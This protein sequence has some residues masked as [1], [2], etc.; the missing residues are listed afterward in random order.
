VEI[1]GNTLD[2]LVGRS[3]TAETPERIEERAE[4][5]QKLCAFLRLPFGH[6][7]SILQ[8]PLLILTLS[9]IS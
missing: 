2:N 4:I 8:T 3:R 7:I 6:V 5:L 1:N 9:P